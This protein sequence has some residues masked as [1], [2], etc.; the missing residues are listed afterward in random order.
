M[1]TQ[2]GLK[3]CHP[4]YQQKQK[5]YHDGKR[6]LQTY[7]KGEKVLILNKQGKTKWLF[8]TTKDLWHIWWSWDPRRDFVNRLCHVHHLLHSRVTSTDSEPEVDDVSDIEL[9]PAWAEPDVS[10]LTPRSESEG[11]SMLVAVQHST[12]EIRAP[13]RLIEEL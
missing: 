7:R 3:Q 11:T 9:T 10:T 5:V 1:F 12:R 8:G 13:H 2:S 6:H 4:K